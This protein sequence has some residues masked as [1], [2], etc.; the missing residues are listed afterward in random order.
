MS[1]YSFKKDPKTGR[2]YIVAND[3]TTVQTGQVIQPPT[4][5]LSQDQ[6]RRFRCT[7]EGC[8]KKFAGQGVAC[9]HYN[10]NHK[11]SDDREEWREFIKEI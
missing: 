7:V 8:N 10:K 11:S 1:N 2:S 5:T 4:V 9:M 6:P 3:Q